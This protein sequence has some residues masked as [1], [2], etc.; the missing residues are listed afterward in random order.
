M[1]RIRN[2]IVVGSLLLLL[3]GLSVVQQPGSLVAQSTGS[4]L[5]NFQE[6]GQLNIPVDVL[7]LVGNFGYAIGGEC[8]AEGVPPVTQCTGVLSV[9][10]TRDPRSMRLLGQLSVGE[11]KETFRALAVHG[12]YAYATVFT[13]PDYGP[14]T[15]VRLG[16]F[17]VSNPK[18]ISEVA[19]IPDV[20][21][22][23]EIHNGQL[24][25]TNNTGVYFY[26]ID[27]PT[28]PAEVGRIS[29]PVTTATL[30][31]SLAYVL[32]KE[33]EQGLYSRLMIFDI[34]NTA[35]PVEVYQV[36][37]GFALSRVIWVFGNRL[38]AIYDSDE[39]GDR[40]GR[41][42]RGS[43]LLEWD[44]SDPR[45]PVDGK[46]IY[47]TYGILH[48]SLVKSGNT[49][50]AIE[51]GTILGFNLADP[52]FTKVLEYAPRVDGKEW[53]VGRMVMANNTVY[54][55][56]HDIYNSTT[57]AL[58]TYR[59]Q[60]PTDFLPLLVIHA[61]AQGPDEN[62]F[63]IG[64]A[65]NGGSIPDWD[66][67]P[68]YIIS[69]IP[70][71]TADQW[72]SWRKMYT[73]PNI[74]GTFIVSRTP[75]S[76]SEGPVHFGPTYTGKI[77]AIYSVPTTV[78]QDYSLAVSVDIARKGAL[79]NA[80]YTD[81]VTG[82]KYNQNA[83]QLL[84]PGGVHLHDINGNNYI[85]CYDDPG[86][87]PNDVNTCNPITQS[88]P[89]DGIYADPTMW[90]TFLD[91]VQANPGRSWGVGFEVPYPPYNPTVD[92]LMY[93]QF[94]RFSIEAIRGRDPTAKIYLLDLGNMAVQL[95]CFSQYYLPGQ[96]NPDPVCN[97]VYWE[98]GTH[99]T[100]DKD[101]FDWLYTVATHY[102]NLTA[103]R[104]N[105]FL[106]DMGISAT[107]DR[108]CWDATNLNPVLCETY[109][110]LWKDAWVT[111]LDSS[112]VPTRSV[113]VWLENRLRPHYI[114]QDDPYR[115]AYI[116]NSFIRFLDNEVRYPLFWLVDDTSHTTIV[117]YF[118]G[119]KPTVDKNQ[120]F[121]AGGSVLYWAYGNQSDPTICPIN[122]WYRHNISYGIRAQ[123]LGTSSLLADDIV[124]GYTL[125]SYRSGANG[126][127][128]YPQSSFDLIVAQGTGTPV[129]VYKA[130]ANND[131]VPDGGIL[132]SIIP[133]GSYGPGSEG[134]LAL[135]KGREDAALMG[136]L[137]Q[138]IA[139]R[140]VKDF[141]F[142]DY[143]I[144]WWFLRSTVFGHDKN[145][146]RKG[147]SQ[148]MR[149]SCTE[150]EWGLLDMD[151]MGYRSPQ[152]EVFWHVV[153][154]GSNPNG[155][156]NYTWWPTGSNWQHSPSGPYC[157]EVSE[158]YLPRPDQNT[159][160]DGVGGTVEFG[161]LPKNW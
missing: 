75:N 144:K 74:L 147:D 22:S 28:A 65:D 29:G 9:F 14:Y 18:A 30:K 11:R 59:F 40:G 87:N 131:G 110:G 140:W 118:N 126:Y 90:N 161:D 56:T 62:R 69:N 97:Q 63:G 141:G 93:A 44:L 94:L 149:D 148:F 36:P 153:T 91:Y 50:F 117:E 88:G 24:V 48:S 17:D 27:N 114:D 37:S 106:I 53:G 95:R 151:G 81:P 99:H 98:P 39:E 122:P 102:K 23:L 15:K 12:N 103:Q 154:P 109:R 133:N 145:D 34:S 108:N 45:K 71:W 134:S 85:D 158:Q 77:G 143:S 54:A 57:S 119:P 121:G 4:S 32:M 73:G 100:R 135:H 70:Y 2:F 96:V 64:D 129:R 21:G 156:P 155:L 107:D 35:N 16:I 92:P 51:N 111:P 26:N 157:I 5:Y 159:N 127:K 43:G 33:S 47:S 67:E 124:A 80:N 76:Y 42:Q 137:A 79:L 25:R 146:G 13:Y 72:T 104:V 31:D 49:L 150:M 6:I 105:G 41:I 160:N 125:C 113:G 89:N 142:S 3:L 130:D 115:G 82:H 123:N 116:W 8:Q 58:R 20:W 136:G 86:F 112:S 84:G 83:H 68:G 61:Y 7:Q 38:Y 152:G 52:K 120:P 19:A 78:G 138:Q 55:S 132:V 10:D 66:A 1:F 46:L 60:S 128:V 101:G 139:L